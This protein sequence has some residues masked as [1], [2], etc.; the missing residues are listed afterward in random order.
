MATERLL[1]LLTA[2]LTALGSVMLGTSSGNVTLPLLTI[3]A[4]TMSIYL[5]DRLRWFYLH[6]SVANLAAL[7]AVLISIYDFYQLERDRQLLAIAYLLVYLQI[8]LLFQIKTHRIYWQL[9]LLS[10]LQVIVATAVSTSLGFGILLIIYLYCCLWTGFVFFV[11]RQENQQRDRLKSSLPQTWTTDVSLAE[12]LREQQ[13]RFHPRLALAALRQAAG[14]CLFAFL[15]FLLLPRIGDGTSHQKIIGTRMIG[16]TDS[17]R[18][19][20]LGTAIE[21]EEPVLR[22]WFFEPGA[23]Q[24]F[25]LLGSPMLRGAVVNYYQ[26]GTWSIA[27]GQH[28]WEQEIE[29]PS[30][31]AGSVRQR[32][33]MTPLRERTVFAIYPPTSIDQQSTVAFNLRTQQMVRT[34]SQS[35]PFD[36]ILGASGIH[37]RRQTRI[38]AI[39]PTDAIGDISL[40][41][42]FH[43][44]ENANAA[45]RR[46]EPLSALA[47][48]ILEE[49]GLT[50][51]TTIERADAL[52]NYL[53]SSP[54]FKYSLTGVK[55]DP[56]LD[57]IIDF[58]TENPEG[59]CEYFSSALTLMLR[60]V[61]IRARMIIGFRGGDWNHLGAYYQIR[62]KDAHSWTEAYIPPDEAQ[63]FSENGSLPSADPYAYPQPERG[64]WLRLDPTPGNS[65]FESQMK[66]G[67]AWQFYG[68]MRNYA[69]FLW[70]KYVIQLDARR[71]Q[72]EIYDRFADW[73]GALLDTVVQK[74]I[75]Q[76]RS[77]QR[78][79][80]SAETDRA[81]PAEPSHKTLD[82]TRLSLWLAI[83]LS[84]TGCI[85]LVR[86]R[87]R[88]GFQ[89]RCVTAKGFATPPRP[90]YRQWERLAARYLARRRPEQTAQ[91]HA[92]QMSD[93]LVA[94][95][96]A[97]QRDIP[98][99]VVDA[100]YAYAYG[101][102]TPDSETEAELSD[103]IVMLGKALATR[104]RDALKT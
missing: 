21:S 96:L 45:A 14:I 92:A 101:G 26:N 80:E 43:G 15:T 9:H 34:T 67:V 19:G 29:I 16:F 56:E 63:S 60:S 99:R 4:A 47:A 104:Q 95:G 57:P 24:A 28:I 35:N 11:V 44:A 87:Y 17:V 75:S 81:A 69:D 88:A 82:W 3:A 61:G 5:T 55:R 18:L 97:N 46:L 12:A 1:Q 65:G 94:Y 89:E 73:A 100:H 79:L 31:N 66:G 76:D 77:E 49:N 62:Q 53:K 85:F 2:L 33:A 102:M 51:A 37:N 64:G 59:H 22:L 30:S 83:L 72:E 32:I 42:P 103:L 25:R 48:R 50:D 84:L 93:R 10:L 74:F 8:V 90:F 13:T 40:L 36:V 38:T 78:S 98:A 41:Q 7:C 20:E 70:T 6:G 86:R 39:G 27:Q 91:A 54:R 68:Q 71:Q 58:L 23:E 52:C